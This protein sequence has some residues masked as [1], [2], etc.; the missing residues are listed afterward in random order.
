GRL[1]GRIEAVLAPF[2]EAVGR[3]TTVPGVDRR[4]A[5]AVAAEIGTDMGRFASDGHLASWA[6]MCPG[7]HESAGRRRSGRTARGN[8]WLKRALVQAAWA[9]SHT[10]GTYLSA[11]Y[12]RL[13]ARRGRKR[14][15]VALGHTLLTILYHLQRKRVEYTDL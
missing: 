7:N 10:K 5:V 8:P 9:A 12:R 13:A 15:L 11:Y 3:W 6:A 4:T 2:A 14:A 1:E